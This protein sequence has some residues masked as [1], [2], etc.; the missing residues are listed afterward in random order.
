MGKSF[1][2]YCCLMCLPEYPGTQVPWSQKGRRYFEPISVVS[3][4]DRA[5][6]YGHQTLEVK[7]GTPPHLTAPSLVYFACKVLPVKYSLSCIYQKGSLVSAF[8]F[9]EGINVL[10]GEA[11]SL[12]WAKL[13]QCKKGW[14]RHLR[15]WERHLV[16]SNLQS[17]S[18]WE[19][20]TRTAKPNPTVCI[21][22][23]LSWK[24]TY[25]FMFFCNTLKL[26]VLSDIH[27]HY[28]G[29]RKC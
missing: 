18:S 10:N 7:A 22:I 16:C 1:S 4:E 17:C 8:Q 14:I 27:S 13:E 24:Q 12:D 6:A 19:G 23:S 20:F 26:C 5:L 29:I 9:W 11:K 25:I 28:E 2:Y 21:Y 3:W 15:D